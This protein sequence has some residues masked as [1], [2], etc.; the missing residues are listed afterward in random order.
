MKR[1]RRQICGMLIIMTL[2]TLCGCGTRRDVEDSLPTET[3][4]Q[5]EA[6]VADAVTIAAP[7]ASGETTVGYLSREIENP[8]W[9]ESFGAC[10]AI[11][12][13]FHIAAYTTD[14]GF[15]VASYDTINDAW[16]R[17]DLITA[18]AYYPGVEL[19][20]AAEDSF[21]VIL[22]EHYT[23]E[24]RSSG[25]LS[26]T[27]NYY[28]VY[29]DAETGEQA[30]TYLN[31]GSVNE[32]YLIALIALDK[33]RALLSD[34]ERTFI[35]N[36]Y[37]EAVELPSLQIMGDGLHVYVNGELYLNSFDGLTHL[38]RESL[39][40]TNVIP[41]IRDQSIY[42]SSLGHFL[43]TKD[44]V[45][46]AVAPSGEETKLFSWM[47]VSLSYSRLCGW[48]GLENSNGEIFHLTDRI[49]KV[50][51]GEI[52][53]KKT[54]K[55]VCL[56]DA[57]DAEYS[58]ANNSYVC[59]DKLKDAILRFNNTD[60]E[61]RVE[62]TPYIYHDENERNKLLIQIATGNEADLI[63]T[64][65]LP[66]GAVDKGLLV[67]ILPYIDADET[68]DRDDFIPTLLNSMIKN[69][70]IY[71][72]VDKYTILTM[73]ISP[74]LAPDTAW[75][76]ESMMTLISQYPELKMP[77]SGEHLLTLFSW[78]ATAEF[79]DRMNGTCDFDSP[80]FAEWLSLLKL[81]NENADRNDSNTYLCGITYDFASSIGLRARISMRGDYL[82]VG[83]PGA[84]GCG[85]YFI[86]LGRPGSI[87][88][89]GYLARELDMYTLGAATSVGIL[90]SGEN[91]DGA[92]RFL[93][94]FIYGEEEPNLR[95]GIPVL[96]DAFEEAVQNELERDVSQENLPYENFTAEDAELLRE[97][98]YGTEKLAST[99]AVVTDIIAGVV[100]PY[101]QGKGSAE[102][103]ARQLQG[104][105]SLYLAEQYG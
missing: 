68:T 28:L 53:V 29:M 33:G 32:T 94:T 80:E 54:L 86:K 7:Q 62:V 65:L 1:Y 64:S 104:K 97:I 36:P 105:M 75:T 50:T 63:D 49:T 24:E 9:V 14:G 46:Y 18:P 77:A 55:L 30:C 103:A 2:L 21:W 76:T 90:A 56:G 19:F 83:F 100:R 60:V 78:A 20:S 99:D 11:G 4:A 17:H 93:R 37:A 15:A 31:C 79:V 81:I 16:Q 51:R 85:S 57:S 61:Y 74:E 73:F 26:R 98:V 12:D 72:Y 8:E 42:S 66:E 91:R 43:T 5:A 71:E 39:Q 95:K 82:P 10:E 88:S 13:F 92:W 48:K 102:D 27:L 25:D 41:A 6:H 38:D 89:N 23:D 87:G 47:D 22:R 52:P 35:L 67:D 45:L 34:G 101:L 40:Y 58:M 70:G 84:S 96:R 44:S 59:S 69:G 3:P